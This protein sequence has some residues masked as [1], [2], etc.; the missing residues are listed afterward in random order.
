MSLQ[1]LNLKSSYTGKGSKILSD[2]L[3][4]SLDNSIEYDRITGYFTID[5]LLSIANIYNYPHFLK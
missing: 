3:L 2:F 5:S 1:D 4:P